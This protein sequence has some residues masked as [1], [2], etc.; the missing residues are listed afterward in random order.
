MYRLAAAVVQ[1]GSGHR[2]SKRW[3][4]TP[5]VERIRHLCICISKPVFILY[6]NKCWVYQSSPFLF[7]LVFG[8]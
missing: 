5:L 3:C 2:I 8:A 4:R 7:V 6:I 1:N